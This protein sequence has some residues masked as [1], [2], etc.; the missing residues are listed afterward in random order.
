MVRGRAAAPLWWVPRLHRRPKDNALPYHVSNLAMTTVNKHSASSIPSWGN[1]SCWHAPAQTS[2]PSAS[3]T[4]QGGR[5][6]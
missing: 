4:L 1:Q 3:R 6:P 5:R 2:K